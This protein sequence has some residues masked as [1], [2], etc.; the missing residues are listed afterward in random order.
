MLIK[1]TLCLSESIG[2]CLEDNRELRRIPASHAAL[3]RNPSFLAFLEYDSIP[4]STALYTEI[5]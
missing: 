1:Y 3:H 4:L 5:Q 2:M